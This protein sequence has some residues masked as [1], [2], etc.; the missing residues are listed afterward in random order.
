MAAKSK[1]KF[2]MYI[3][4]IVERMTYLYSIPSL[5]LQLLDLHVM[6]AC[7][8]LLR[9]SAGPTL[10]LVTSTFFCSPPMHLLR[11]QSPVLM[12][13]NADRSTHFDRPDRVLLHHAAPPSWPAVERRKV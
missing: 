4:H 5:N 10:P 2:V 3:F 6:N 9:V 11:H 8:A 12:K 1:A 7:L 13:Q